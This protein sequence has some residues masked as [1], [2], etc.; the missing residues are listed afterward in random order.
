MPV[1]PRPVA[2]MLGRVKNGVDTAS[3]KTPHAILMNCSRRE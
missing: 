3:S 2:T 1:T